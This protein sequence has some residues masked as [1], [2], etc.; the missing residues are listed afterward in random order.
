MG[1]PLVGSIG[2][3]GGGLAEAFDKGQRQ[4]ERHKNKSAPGRKNR[5]VRQ[6]KS[7]KGTGCR[8]SV[9]RLGPISSETIENLV[10]P[11]PL[12]AMQRLVQRR[13]LLIGD[14]ADLLDRLDVLLIQRIDDATDLL[15]LLRQANAD[16][17]TINARALM[18]EEAELDQL[19]QVVGDVGAEIVAA[20]AQ[21]ARGQLLVADIV[22]EQSLHRIDVGAA[23]AIELVLDNI[24]QAAMQPL[25]QRQCFQIERLHGRLAGSTVGG[26]HRRRNGFHHDTSPVVDL[27]TYSTK[28]MSRLIAAI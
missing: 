19:L 9:S 27:S 3:G 18:I 2:V 24:K 1:F 14:A 22:Q 25:H 23:T 8:S 11:E 20:R 17:T 13:E 4:A 7:L 28:L 5:S 26:F 16:R 6:G 12:E 10:G 15:A 21:F